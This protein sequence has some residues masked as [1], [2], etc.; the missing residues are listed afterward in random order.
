MLNYKKF[1]KL[2]SYY[3]LKGA[4][5]AEKTREIGRFNVKFFYIKI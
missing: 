4:R 2:Y 3:I 1:I 5:K